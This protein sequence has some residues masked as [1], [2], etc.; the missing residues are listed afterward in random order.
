[1][2]GYHDA[3]GSL[4]SSFVDIAAGWILGMDIHVS[5]VLR[6]YFEGNLA[7]FIY[8]LAGWGSM[9]RKSII[10]FAEQLTLQTI[11]SWEDDIE[12]QFGG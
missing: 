7:P 12:L 1:V 8:A 3:Y 2:V 5:V 11:Q 4:F 6:G 9:T 10:L